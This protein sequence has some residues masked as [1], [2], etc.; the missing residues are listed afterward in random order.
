[1][2]LRADFFAADE[3]PLLRVPAQSVWT[4]RCGGA[5]LHGDLTQERDG[6]VPASE[7]S[8]RGRGFGQNVHQSSAPRSWPFDRRFN[9]AL[10][11]SGR[12]WVGLLH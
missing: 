2:V 6:R 9:A 10:G 1:M 8:G 7:R 5:D 11:G 3:T 4:A 12:V